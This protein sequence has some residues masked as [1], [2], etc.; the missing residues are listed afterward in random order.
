MQ[1][2]RVRDLGIGFIALAVLLAIAGW[3]TGC[4]ESNFPRPAYNGIKAHWADSSSTW[5]GPERMLVCDNGGSVVGEV[6]NIYSNG[7]WYA[8][9]PFGDFVYQ[10][11]FETEYEA[12]A[13]VESAA[14]EKSLCH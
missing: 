11:E 14:K 5:D 3:C 7:K 1:H 6:S 9:A 10:K 4:A 2:N 12:M 8:D 13:A